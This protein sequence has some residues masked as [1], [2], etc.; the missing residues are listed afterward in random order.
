MFQKPRVS[1]YEQSVKHLVYPD[2]R[3]I[4]LVGTAHVSSKSREMVEKILQEVDPDVIALEL[5]SKRID[6]MKNKSRFETMDIF[7]IIRSGETFF[8]VGH[9]LLASFQRKIS[10]RTG[11][12]AGEE[13]LSALAIAEEKQK[14][15]ELIDRPIHVTLK[16][17]WN[18]SGFWQ[19]IKMLTSILFP[20]SEYDNLD[21][22]K[23]ERLKDENELSHI[24]QSLSEELPFVKEVLIDERDT[25]LAGKIQQIREKITVAVIGA[26]HLPGVVRALQ[27]PIDEAYLKSLEK[28]PANSLLWKIIPWTIPFLVI[29]AFVY[30]L[31]YGD[32]ESVKEALWGWIFINGG[33]TAL[34]CLI[35]LGHP[36]TIIT[37]FV[38][39]PLTSLNPAIG[40]GF[41]TGLVQASLVRP[42]VIDFVNVQRNMTEIDKWWKN[43]L[44]KTLMVFILSS[45]GSA[46]GTF[47]AF[48]FLA[49]MVT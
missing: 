31:F 23:I 28:I 36:L 24:F 38:A 27:K 9:L 3:E 49:R 7:K 45:L 2:G 8:F 14:K 35:A 12:R 6:V 42:R 33:L 11:T 21:E 5:D 18:K 40:A 46:A 26:G 41:V 25:Y 13:F 19:Q 10:D 4:Y 20:G 37:G 29:G 34:G 43:R 30:G 47:L 16:R 39:A 48:P 32:P 15:L 22:D 17:A 44:I 1:D